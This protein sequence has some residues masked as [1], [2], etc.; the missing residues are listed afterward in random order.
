M[1]SIGVIRELLCIGTI[2]VSQIMW[3]SYN[4]A[5]IMILPPGAFILIGYMVG[6]VKILLK[7]AEEKEAEKARQGGSVA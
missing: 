5:L 1:L 2:F 7:R 6:G 3:S 4:P